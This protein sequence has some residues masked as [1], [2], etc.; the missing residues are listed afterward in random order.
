VTTNNIHGCYEK[1]RLASQIPEGHRLEKK[2][3]KHG[4]PHPHEKVINTP[5]KQEN[6][7]VKKDSDVMAVR[8]WG[9]M[10]R[11]TRGWDIGC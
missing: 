11:W 3:P 8:G 6:N 9:S 4:Y 10:H 7:F 2:Q 5:K 1:E